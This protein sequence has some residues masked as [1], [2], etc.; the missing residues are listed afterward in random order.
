M[1]TLKTEG[2]RFESKFPKSKYVR[3][4]GVLPP[5]RIQSMTSIKYVTVSSNAKKH[6]LLDKFEY[7][8]PSENPYHSKRYFIKGKTFRVITDE[9]EL[10]S[11]I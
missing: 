3:L 5:V 4:M 10:K 9:D 8:N 7:Q 6:I 1:I 2:G 11:K